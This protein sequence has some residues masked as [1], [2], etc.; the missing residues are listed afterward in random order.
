MHSGKWHH[1]PAS[2]K[3]FMLTVRYRDIKELTDFKSVDSK[4]GSGHH[5]G[6]GPEALLLLSGPK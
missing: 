6:S 4:K 3:I 2:P 5:D 1:S